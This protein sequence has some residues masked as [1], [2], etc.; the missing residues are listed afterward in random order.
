[1]IRGTQTGAAGYTKLKSSGKGGRSSGELRKM[2]PASC[3]EGKMGPQNS[4]R[5]PAA[6]PNSD[7][8]RRGDTLIDRGRSQ[9]AVPGVTCR[10]GRFHMDLAELRPAGTMME[11]LI[12]YRYGGAH[13]HEHEE[14]EACERLTKRLS[15]HAV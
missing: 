6:N 12:H 10:P 3:D 9:S 14:E 7:R 4:E 1:M 15:Y 11:K 13:P 2:P 8:K 5:T